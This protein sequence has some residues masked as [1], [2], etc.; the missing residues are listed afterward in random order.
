MSF[1]KITAD[2]K[3]YINIDVNMKFD[4]LKP[5]IL[6][7]AEHFIKPLLGNQFHDE[8]TTAYTTA[9]TVDELSVDIKA[10]LPYIQ[11]AH[12]YYTAYLMVDEIGVQVGDLGIQQQSNANSQPAPAW[13]IAKLVMK[14]ITSADA[15][16]D[17]LLEY[18][19]ENASPTKYGTWYGDIIANTA[20]T[21]CIVYKTSVASKYIDIRG[22]RRVFLRLKKRI[23]DIEGSYVKRL[24]CKDQ[25][26][27]IVTQLK[28]GSLTNTNAK[29]VAL[30]EPIISKRALYLTLPSLAISIEAQGIMMYSS[31]DSVIQKQTAGNE[32]KKQ[33]MV[34][35]K[36]GDFGYEADEAELD[37]F[38]TENIQSFP[39]ISASPCWASK[40]SDGNITWGPDNHCSDK[41]F[42]V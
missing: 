36:E 11:R 19:E 39:L 13:K 2:V 1:F 15:A 42:S 6:D 27:E 41:H 37:A 26:E 14:Y 10:L 21:G 29:L 17:K 8:L 40:P 28:T 23:T 22:N 12:A 24:I 30:L 31:N 20:M 5:S 25:Y 32:E 7:A 9:T 18:L 3:R 33:L 16:A 35:L 38:L 4:K 34:S